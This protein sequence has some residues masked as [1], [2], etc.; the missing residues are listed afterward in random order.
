MKKFLQAF[1]LLSTICIYGQVGISN[2][3]PKAQLDVAA[4]SA[5]APSNTDGILIPRVNAFPATNPTAAQNGMM[6]FLTT[7]AGS[8]QPGFYYWEQ[9][10][11][12][13]KGVGRN[14]A[15]Q[16][17]LDG[18]AGTTPAANF[19]GT[20]DN[21]D[22]VFKRFNQEAGRIGNENVSFG[23][24]AGVS[25]TGL[26]NSFFGTAAGQFNA[27]GSR[28]VFVGRYAGRNGTTGSDNLF[29]GYGSGIGNTG[30]QNLFMGTFSGNANA[31]GDNNVF[32]GY[33]SGISNSSGSFNTLLGHNSRVDSNNLTNAAA[34]GANATVGAS[35]ALVLGST[36]G[37][38]GAT[39]SSNVGIGT[40]TPSAGFDVT[41]TNKGIL[42]PRVALTAAN[43]QAPIVNPQGGSIPESTLIYNTATDGAAPNAVEPGFYYW[44]ASKWVRFDVGGE[45]TP[46]VYTVAGTTNTPVTAVMTPMPEMSITFTPND[47]IAFVEFSAGGFGATN[48]CT[49]SAIF[50][51]LLIDGSPVKGFQ[52]TIEQIANANVDRPLW[53]VFFKEAIAVTPNVPLTVSISWGI[54]NCSNIFN[55]VSNALPS[56]S[57]GFTYRAH[58]TLVVTDPNGGGGASGTPVQ[59]EMWG[60]NGNSGTDISNFIGTID[61]NDV[62]FKRNNVE[63]GRLGVNRASFGAFAL[64]ENFDASFGTFAL[65]NTF[66]GGL[67]S[68]FGS[69]ALFNNISGFG[70]TAIGHGGMETN[71]SGFYNTTAGAYADVGDVDLQNA[72]AIGCMARVDTSNAVVL[73]SVAGVNS[74][75]SDVN[76]GIGTTL[77]GSALEIADENVV[78]SSAGKGNLNV[79]S[80]NPGSADIGGAITFG[81]FRDAALSQFRVYGSIEGR[82]TTASAISS[83][84]YL[85]LKTNTAGVLTE[86]IR[87]THDGRVGI[88]TSTPGATLHVGT[89]NVVPT[90]TTPGNLAIVSANPQ[91][92]NV[93]SALTF[94][95]NVTAADERVFASIEGRKS[96]SISGSSNSYLQIRTND[97]ANLSEKMRITDAGDV[98]IGTPTP[99]GQ[100]ELSLNEGRK[101]GSTTWT[102]P[103]DERLK[104]VD[105][106]F[107]KGL[108]EIAALRPIRYHYKNTADKTFD[109]K[110]LAEEFTGFLAQEVRAIFPEA[111]KTDADGYLNFN[112]HPILVAM[113]NAIKE[114]KEKN[115]RLEAEI[116]A[117]K[118]ERPADIKYAELA[119]E[120]ASQRALL[121]SVQQEL[122]TR[123]H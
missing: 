114:L 113:V 77:P 42:I 23:R 76:V 92:I 81:G 72:T 8:N 122:K 48:V 102:I 52:T 61:S 37:V 16:W 40:T 59:S 88:N 3:D 22:L 5:A 83:D 112:M 18:N 93:G 53:D 80:K 1:I 64:A 15:N 31:G 30:D 62:V 86:K 109:E 75:T 9:A 74:A 51:E 115:E 38:N 117:L 73:G 91:A 32:L 87:V 94:G 79:M 90:A 84:G 67:N 33:S 49:E 107:T 44:N 54:P 119:R 82:K 55:S 4:S 123:G 19:I 70:N 118:T 78:T 103:S 85:A 100:F 17:N 6:V 41:S 50:F 47:A 14:T 29:F 101:P 116:L 60:I 66:G 36:G 2:T 58:R 104:N 24:N 56:G 10:T 21:Q 106:G 65:A 11:T 71:E 63:S 20:T 45:K 121:E 7:A 12:S 26:Y 111:V 43:V 95:G 68:A 120:I 105:G 13:W 89:Q 27:G 98:G 39:A 69:S 97:G 99:G 108:S 34:I 25:N 96:N 28:N 35:N 46:K 57:T 110:V